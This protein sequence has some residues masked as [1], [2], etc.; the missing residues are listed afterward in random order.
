M[1]DFQNHR[2]FTLRCL[3]EKVIPVSIK[4]K[5]HVKIPKGFQI[6]RTAEISLLNERVRSINN[7]INMLSLQ[8]DTCIRKLKEKIGEDLMKECEIF[9]EKRSQT[10]QDHVQAKDET[11]GLVP[12]SNPNRGG[13]SNNRHSSRGDQPHCNQNIN[14]PN[15]QSSNKWV[16]DISDKPLS[17]DE[18]R[19]LAHGPSFAIVLKDPPI[20]QYV[21]AI[22]HACTK[23]EEG[24]VEELRVQVKVAIQRIQ[25]PKPN[26]SRG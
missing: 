21:A 12:K 4:L 10:F 19:L 13:C 7:T 14:I 17:A 1:V 25:K 23:L 15:G 2:H 18:E 5:S 8:K 22:E 20:V 3:G 6:I 24:K 11:R 16:I 9:I 26:I